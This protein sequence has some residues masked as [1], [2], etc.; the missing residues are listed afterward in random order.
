MLDAIWS[1]AAG[2]KKSCEGEEFNGSGTDVAAPP[3]INMRAA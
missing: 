1:W 3:R 2:K